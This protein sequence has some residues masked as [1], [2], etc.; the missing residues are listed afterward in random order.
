MIYTQIDKPI[1][2]EETEIV[3]KLV[4]HTRKRTSL[5]FTENSCKSLKIWQFKFCEN[6]QSIE[7]GKLP[8]SFYDISVTKI[9]QSDENCN[10]Q[11]RFIPEIQKW[12]SHR[13]S[14]CYKSIHLKI[15]RNS[16]WSFS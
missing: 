7:E 6:F 5:S 10:D 3:R 15:K 16:L 4:P 2:I 13:K 8:G 1:S 11:I 12:F 14:I 9:S